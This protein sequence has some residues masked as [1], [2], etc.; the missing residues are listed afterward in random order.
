MQISSGLPKPLARIEFKTY[1]MFF[2]VIATVGLSPFA[3]P[4]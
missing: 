4:S 3:S 2:L 1:W